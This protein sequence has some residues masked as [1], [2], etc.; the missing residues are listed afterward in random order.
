MEAGAEHALAEA[1][2]FEKIFWVSLISDSFEVR[3]DLL[4]S[5]MFAFPERA[6]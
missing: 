6:A 5:R 4:P 1:A 3:P 2:V